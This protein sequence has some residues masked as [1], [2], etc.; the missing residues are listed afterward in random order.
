[1]PVLV[2]TRLTLLGVDYQVPGPGP[3]GPRSLPLAPRREIGATPP[4]KIG[5]HDLFDDLLGGHGVEDF[6]KGGVAASGHVIVDVAGLYRPDVLHYPP[7]LTLPET[8]QV[9]GWRPQD[10]FPFQV[11]EASA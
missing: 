8:G 9:V 11:E 6:V 5:P 1:M 10:G 7:L 4:P 3:R 2:Y